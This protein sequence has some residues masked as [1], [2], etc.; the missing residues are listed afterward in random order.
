MK[1]HL[2]CAK[3]QDVDAI[4]Q[5]YNEAIDDRQATLET[6]RRDPGE[7]GRWLAA[8]EARYPVLVA[9]EDGRVVAWGSLNPFN[10]RPCYDGVADFSV[11]VARDR[12]GEGLGGRLVEAL[13]DLARELGYHKLVL[14]ALARNGA[15]RKLYE[16]M[17]FREVGIYREQGK[18]DGHW[19]DVL[20]MELLLQ[21]P[22]AR[23]E[24]SDR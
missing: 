21:V 13:I 11:Y 18:L 10:S 19:E 2:R 20:L 22:K 14:A 3:P 17:G 1:L 9:T 23:S 16:K 5:I 8:R 6:E 24:S 4:C 12:R 7:R 15:G